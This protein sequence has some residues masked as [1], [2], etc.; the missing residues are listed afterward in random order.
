MK[1]INKKNYDPMVEACKN[2]KFKEYYQDA[3]SR[4]DLAINVYNFRKQK[5][6]SQEELAEKA[7]TTQKIISK[8]ENSQMN[9]GWDLIMRVLGNLGLKLKI[10]DSSI[11]ELDCTQQYV[12]RI[13]SDWNAT[14]SKET[15]SS[16]SFVDHTT[17]CFFSNKLSN[18]N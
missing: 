2:P 10:I 18:S 5:G 7:S 6:L 17:P 9:V 8:I 15:S 13:L 16:K 4:I 3:C 12:Y 11:I 1:Y 14:N